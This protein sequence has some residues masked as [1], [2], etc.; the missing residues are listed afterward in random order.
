[1]V[2]QIPNCIRIG[3]PIANT[4]I[5]ILSEDGRLLPPGVPGQLWISGAGLADGYWKRS[6]L[7]AERFAEIAACD[8]VRVLAYHTGDVARWHEDGTLEC[9]GRSDGQLKIRGFRVDPGEIEAVLASHP[10]VAQARVAL[11]GPHKLEGW[12]T[13][14]KEAA[15]PCPDAL[16]SFL[17]ERLPVYMLPADIGIIES[18][19]LNS[20]GKVDLSKLADP[21]AMAPPDNP[22]TATEA[23]LLG[24]WRELLERSSVRTDDNWFH[25]GGHSLLALRLFARIHQDFN[26]RLPISAILAHPTPRALAGIIDAS[27][28]ATGP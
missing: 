25:I 2:P 4:G 17:A 21:Q 7:N 6:D 20:S 14:E 10:Q 8:G 19:P 12:I 22:V 16:K 11:R 24:L 23:A 3:T 5:H 1:M 27:Q 18:F 28:P 13:V 9:L 26:R 15:N